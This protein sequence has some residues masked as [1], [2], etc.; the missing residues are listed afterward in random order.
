[1]KGMPYTIIVAKQNT[2]HYSEPY[3]TGNMRKQKIIQRILFYYIKIVSIL[4]DNYRN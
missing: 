4:D 2:N 3:K 1:M